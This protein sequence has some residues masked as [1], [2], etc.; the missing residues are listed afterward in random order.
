VVLEV[1]LLAQVEIL[2]PLMQLQIPEV[3]LALLVTTIQL[4]MLTEVEMADLASSL[5]ATLVHKKEPAARSPRAA[6]TPTTPSLR[7]AHSRHKESI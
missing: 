4:D 5:F 6:A 3:V 1:V 7:P 2:D